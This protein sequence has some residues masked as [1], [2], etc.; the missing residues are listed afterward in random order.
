VKSAIKG[1]PG[2]HQDGDSMLPRIFLKMTG[3]R[4]PCQ[5][6]G[7]GAFYGAHPED[8]FEGAMRVIW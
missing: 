1:T 6:A 4:E 5:H 3:P 8:L 2:G 7:N